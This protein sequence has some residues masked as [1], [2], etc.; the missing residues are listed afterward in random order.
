MA[1]K[2]PYRTL[3]HTHT[4]NHT[5]TLAFKCGNFS[6]FLQSLF[7]LFLLRRRKLLTWQFVIQKCLSVSVCVWVSV[8]ARDAALLMAAVSAVVDIL[9]VTVMDHLLKLLKLPT[10]I[11]QTN[12]RPNTAPVPLPFPHPHSLRLIDWLMGQ[13]ECSDD[14]DSSANWRLQICLWKTNII[15]AWMLCS[16]TGYQNYYMHLFLSKN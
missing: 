11:S 9:T 8:R 5:D 13:I 15:I 10:Q 1:S 14:D 6:T 7:I 4:H 16:F 2:F 12:R 3:T